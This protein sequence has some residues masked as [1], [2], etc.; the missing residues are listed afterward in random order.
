[1]KRTNSDLLAFAAVLLPAAV[2]CAAGW[3]ALPD[4]GRSTAS[5]LSAGL[6]LVVNGLLLYLIG[7][8][9]MNDKAYS[10]TVAAISI[11]SDLLD[12]F[13]KTEPAAQL[14]SVVKL[15]GDFISLGLDDFTGGYLS[16]AL[17]AVGD[18]I[19]ENISK[20]L[21]YYDKILY[22]DLYAYDASNN[23]FFE[24]LAPGKYTTVSN[25]LAAIK[26]AHPMADTNKKINEC[27]IT[28]MNWKILYEDQKILNEIYSV[29]GES[30]TM[31]TNDFWGFVESYLKK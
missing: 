16:Y 8:K 9:V 25:V 3:L 21:N 28:L 12:F 18:A 6:I 10:K 2:F 30:I 1:M 4:A 15:A 5:G 27:A 29:L 26:A 31:P 13:T 17:S 20:A 14:G 23:K 22:A 7:D 24:K 11:S 19:E